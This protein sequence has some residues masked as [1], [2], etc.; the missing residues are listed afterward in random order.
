[1]NLA[2]IR[3]LN[4]FS[5]RQGAL[6]IRAGRAMV[7]RSSGAH[8]RYLP[9]PILVVCFDFQCFVFLHFTAA[10]PYHERGNGN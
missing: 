4:P 3:A 8:F 10:C 2:I 7:R 5:N 9:F 6:A 1:M